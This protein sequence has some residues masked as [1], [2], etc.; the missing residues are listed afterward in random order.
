MN[1]E[2]TIR[3]Y[4]PEEYKADM[5]KLLQEKGLKEAVKGYLDKI[6]QE[7]GALPYIPHMT[8]Q[9]CLCD[10]LFLLELAEDKE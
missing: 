2:I 3:E 10:I 8:I 5:Q 9:E 6:E 7:A 4:T 1:G